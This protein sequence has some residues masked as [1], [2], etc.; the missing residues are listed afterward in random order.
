MATDAG[1]A[2][3]LGAEEFEKLASQLSDAHIPVSSYPVGLRL[4]LQLLGALAVQSGGTVI[5]DGGALAGKDA[6]RALAIAADTSVLWPTSVTW[7]AEMTE[8]FPKRLPPLRPDRA[9]IVLGTFKGKGPLNA[10]IGVAGPAGPQEIA[11]SVSPSASDE[12]N[13]YLPQLIELARIDGGVTL[14]L[15]GSESLAEARRMVTSEVRNI[16]RLARQALANGNLDAAEKLI[17]KALRQDPNDVEAL[18]LKSALAKRKQGGA[19]AEAVPAPPGRARQNRRRRS[20]AGRRRWGSEPGWS[21]SGGAAR[22]RIGRRIPEKSAGDGAG[23]PDG[24]D[25]RA[26]PGPFDDE[27]GSGHGIATTEAHAGKRAEQRRVG[28]RRARPVCR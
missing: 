14:P 25:K 13:N 12:S 9:T 4:D 3:L 5:S 6:G 7:P 27:H 11:L 2:H 26:E 23:D 1:A 8:V 24:G 21:C 28:S 19:A 20:S 17:G 18:S 15:V 22:G 16:N 10:K